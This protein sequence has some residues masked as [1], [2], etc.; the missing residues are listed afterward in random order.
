MNDAKVV[1]KVGL[2]ASVVSN[3]EFGGV[4]VETVG[5]LYVLSRPSHCGHL[6]VLE[7]KKKLMWGTNDTQHRL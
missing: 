1:T 5:N 6:Q 3:S 7:S 2:Q 4:T